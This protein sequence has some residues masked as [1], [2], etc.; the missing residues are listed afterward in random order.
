MKVKI[1]W[2]EL[3]YVLLATISR[4]LSIKL[5]SIF[6]SIKVFILVAKKIEI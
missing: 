3:D 5:F 2:C 4:R 1:Q 6:A